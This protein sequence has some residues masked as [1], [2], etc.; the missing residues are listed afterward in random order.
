V[1]NLGLAADGA[2]VAGVDSSTQSCKIVVCQAETGRIV[3]T[4]RASHPAGTEVSAEA[5][6]R[7]FAAASAEP[8]LLDGV[9]AMAVAGQQDGMVTLDDAGNL[10]RDALLWNDNRSAADAADL[11]VELGGPTAWAEAVGSVPVASMTVAKLPGLPDASLTTPPGRRRRYS[12]T[13]G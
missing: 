13:T 7:A 10:V 12:R 9:Q 11:I 8:D 4:G 2:L 1:T 3:R 5:W 6:W